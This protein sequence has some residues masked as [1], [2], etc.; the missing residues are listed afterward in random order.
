MFSLFLEN[1]NVLRRVRT[2]VGTL[3][4]SDKQKIFFQEQNV[5]VDQ[6]HLIGFN[7]ESF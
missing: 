7:Y 3:P 6:G 4:G 5:T 1:L 2:I